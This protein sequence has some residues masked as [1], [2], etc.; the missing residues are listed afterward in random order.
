[1]DDSYI[2]RIIQ[3]GFVNKQIDVKG[4]LSI[5]DLFGKSKPRCGIYC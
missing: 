5:S 3:L 1:M 2:E 4:R